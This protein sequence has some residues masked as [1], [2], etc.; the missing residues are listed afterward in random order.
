MVAVPPAA[1]FC[2]GLL[3]IVFVPDDRL[4]R[5]RAPPGDGRLALP[6]DA[7]R[8]V[9]MADAVV[10]A[11]TSDEATACD[12]GDWFTVGFMAPIGF[13]LLIN[14]D[15]VIDDEDDLNE[16]EPVKC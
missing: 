15:D 2:I 3:V 9:F 4:L 5:L 7:Y 12:D 8:A 11:E 16:H 14:S 1:A 13:E 10:A 6:I